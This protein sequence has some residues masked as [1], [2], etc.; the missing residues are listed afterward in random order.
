MKS[1]PHARFQNQISRRAFLQM[2]GLGGSAALLAACGPAAPTAA[3]TAAVPPTSAAPVSLSF[4]T[5]GGSEVFCQGFNT[6]AKNYM[7]VAANVTV[8]DAQCY[9]G[10]E[11]FREVLLANIAGGNPPDMTIV[12]ESPV[13]YAARGA[14]EPLD[15]MMANSKYAK[16]ENWPAGV[17]ASCQFKGQTY[18]LPATAGTYGMFYNAELFESKGISSKREDFPKTW[19]EL[20]RL[21]KEFTVWNGDTLESVGFLPWSN[22]DDLYSMAVELAVWSALNGSQLFDATNLKYTLD[23]EQNIEMMQYAVDWLEEEYKGDYIKIRTARNWGGYED[24]N[25]RPPSFQQNKQAVLT[26]GFWF[27]G[28]MY[29]TALEFKNWDAASFPVGPSGSKTASGYWPNWLVIPKGSKNL[30]AS[31]DYLDYMSVEGI[32]VWFSNIPDIPSNLQV[33]NDLIP[34]KVREER[35]DAF[36]QDITAF[37]RGQLK[38]ATPMWNSPVQD[39][40]LDQIGRAAEQILTKTASPKDALTEAQTLCQAE[41]DKVLKG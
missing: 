37:F 18:G 16:L 14:L 17:L 4:W 12:W 27:T 24:G 26:N 5:P 13:A 15:A 39:F 28:D 36:A 20:R 41:L 6:I 25:A 8:G 30:Q 21:S 10:N 19:D 34:T 3:P 9:S 29:G 38:V 40:A 32:K 35:G 23:S 33:P 2:A 22:P 7:Q 1:N 11:A 31:F